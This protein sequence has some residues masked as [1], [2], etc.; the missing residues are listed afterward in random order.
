MTPFDSDLYKICIRDVVPCSYS[1][2]VVLRSAVGEV[3]RVSAIVLVNCDDEL[4][5]QLKFRNTKGVEWQYV[6]ME[7]VGNDSFVGEVVVTE[8]CE[9]EFQVCAW[10]DKL[11]SWQKRLQKR[12]N[13]GLDIRSDLL[14]GVDMLTP[15]IKF[16]AKENVA[17]IEETIKLLKQPICEYSI[18]RASSPQLSNIV[19]SSID[20]CA[21][22]KSGYVESCVETLWIEP[23]TARFSSWYEMFIRSAG[24]S[25]GCA[26]TFQDA[27]NRLK[28]IADMG[29]DVL[30]LTPIYPCK[31]TDSGAPNPWIVG[32]ADGGHTQIAPELGNLND[33]RDF[34]KNAKTLGLEIALDLAFSCSC[35]HPFLKEHPEWFYKRSDGTFRCEEKS[36][37]Q[38]IC[39]INFEC[40]QWQ[41]LWGE[42]GNT[43]RFWV[44]EGVRFFRVCEFDGVPFGFWS[45]LL[46]EMR[47]E[48]PDVVFLVGDFAFPNNSCHNNTQELSRIGFSQSYTDFIL[49]D[50]KWELMRFV[51]ELQKPELR[52]VFR[53]NFFTNT[54]NVLSRTLQYGGRPVFISKLILAAT[55]SGNYGI[56]SGYEL[57]ENDGL[58]ELQQYREPEIFKIKPRNWDR[59]GNIKA[60]IK[61]IN[62]IRVRYPVLQFFG[63]AIM[64]NI[65]NDQML[66]YAKVGNGLTPLLIVVSLDAWKMQGG[67]LQVP[68][69]LFNIKE[70]QPYVVTDL[71]T[72]KSYNWQGVQNY[73]ELSHQKMPAHIFSISSLEAIEA[74]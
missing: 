20:D 3:F 34:Q 46:R 6:T 17:Y 37:N 11:R 59:P 23:I 16:V 58:P 47:C 67:M 68:L 35:E 4:V 74:I 30:C 63:N 44:A 60:I 32:S 1:G 25:S 15:V 71:L 73:V 53:P 70:N 69:S 2:A 65:E 72:M 62:F 22:I 5:V 14:E 55:L 24:I 10:V 19:S 66:A 31:T 54:H 39:V 18:S 7:S 42:L 40:E 13:T 49:Q 33:F 43:V 29:F 45:W 28:D 48:F 27:N 61:S 38:S 26:A 21:G 9:H 50:T 36:H 57:C 8:Q 56:Y 52:N 64:C 51:D 41:S 12:A